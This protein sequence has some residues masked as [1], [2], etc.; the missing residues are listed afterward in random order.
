MKKLLLWLLMMSS[1][2]VN[3]QN[4]EIITKINAVKLSMQG[5]EIVREK[6]MT[7]SP[8][9][10]RLTFVGLSPK[11]NAQS[12]QVTATNE[13]QVLSVVG[14]INFLA[15]QKESPKI[16]ALR[17]SIALLNL[18]FQGIND[19]INAFSVEEAMLKENL[20]IRGEA[21]GLQISELEKSADFFRIRFREIY[22][23]RSK[24][25]LRKAKIQQEITRINQQ[26]NELNAGNRYTSEIEMTLNAKTT[27]TTT[28]KL[29]YVVNDAGWSPIYDLKAT[30][31][32]KP[33]N[34]KYR[35]LAYNNTGI[36]WNDIKITLSTSDPNAP[37]MQPTLRPWMLN[38]DA[39][40][41]MAER[42]QGVFSEHNSNIWNQSTGRTNNFDVGAAEPE[43]VNIRFET[44][45]I[46]ELDNDFEIAELYT[47]P[48][49][50]KPYSIDVNSH[51]LEASFKHIAIPKMDKD[52]FLLAQITGWESLNL[53][54]GPMNVYYGDSYIGLSNLS[55]RTLGDTLDLSLGRDRRVLVTRVKL[56]EF[57]KKQMLGSYQT[58]TYSY[59]ISVKNNRNQA[60]EI[61]LEDQIP[62]STIKEIEV[63]TV[64]ISG[65]TLYDNTG[66][67]KW[68]MNLQ[69][70]ETK[71]IILTF[72]VKYPKNKQIK[73]EQK[74]Q[75]VTP[76]Y[77]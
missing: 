16:N 1:L 60:V 53:I 59:K 34:L 76:R 17:D 51:D 43:G 41:F 21:N 52:A 67:T 45:E 9:T 54:D 44:I 11:I 49:D 38:F 58:A 10:T 66:K 25:N 19:Y 2:F 26:L 65:A 48:S 3:A 71:S 62:V 14:K 29:R 15:R 4:Q 23:E 20:K 31:L 37:A 68:K 28:V 32:D 12:V 30:E 77:F 57:T 7:L 47:I 18:D 50:R 27:K 8:G 70:G 24:L 33:I 6:E 35:A 55:T 22:E 69:P 72:T 61:D 75:I 40:D 56:K 5:A 13:V 63:N 46:S 64:E 39:N 74:K 36:D 73:L 42:N